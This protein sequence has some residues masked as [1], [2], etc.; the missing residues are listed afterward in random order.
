MAESLL[1]SFTEFEPD[2]ISYGAIRTND[3]GGKSIRIY[4]QEKNNLTISTPLMLC[5][6]IQKVL[7]KKGEFTGSYSMS[8]QFP[9]D[10]FMNEECRIF[11]KKMKEFEEKIMIDGMQNSKEWFGKAD[12]SRELVEDKYNPYLRYPKD[13]ESGEFDYSR[14]PTL[15]VKIPFWEGKFNT[16]IYNTDKERIF[17]P[18]TEEQLNGS[19]IEDIVPKASHLVCALECGGFWFAM[20]SFGVTWRL[21]QAIVRPP[22]RLEGKC[23]LSLSNEDENQISKIKEREEKENNNIEEDNDVNHVLVA[24]SDEENENEEKQEEEKE[25][26]DVETEDDTNTEPP[27]PVRKPRARVTRVR[28]TKN[29]S[30]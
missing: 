16:T 1:T 20:G 9:K 28:K 5:W 19:C 2:T 14:S 15:R 4:N 22:Y 23:F 12:M 7:N 26:D 29:V 6:G 3:S 21:K 10:D 24:D 11:L 27:E 25:N 30:K 17:H 8:L 13:K 18:G